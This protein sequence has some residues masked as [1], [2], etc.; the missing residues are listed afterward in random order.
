[1]NITFSKA[2][3]EKVYTRVRLWPQQFDRLVCHRPER[4]GWPFHV[5]RTAE[6]KLRRL[7]YLVSLAVVNLKQQPSN[8]RFASVGRNVRTT[9]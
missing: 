3:F 9:R 7:V 2:K 8:Q 6:R 1:M 5:L 4:H